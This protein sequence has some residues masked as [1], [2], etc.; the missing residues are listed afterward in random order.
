MT[1]RAIFLFLCV[2]AMLWGQDT[3]P[4]TAP[5]GAALEPPGPLQPGTT[6]APPDKRIFGVLPNYRTANETAVY[7]P[8]TI[9]QK[10]IIGT[11][12]SFDY[13]LFLVA[14]GIFVRSV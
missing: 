3:S 5:A 1:L 10:F 4:N 12:D 2:G 9:K 11:K 13:P 7:T 14:A 6:Q 8:I